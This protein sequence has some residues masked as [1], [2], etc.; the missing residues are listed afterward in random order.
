MSPQPEIPM[1]PDDPSNDYESLRAG[2]D[3]SNPYDVQYWTSTLA[4]TLSQLQLAVNKVGT[5]V[6]LVRQ[7]LGIWRAG[8]RIAHPV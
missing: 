4:V 2:I 1:A 3:L 6:T 7:Y 8:E 5:N